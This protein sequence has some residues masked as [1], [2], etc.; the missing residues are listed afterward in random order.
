MKFKKS[1]LK[2]LSN[3]YTLANVNYF[4]KEK[5]KSLLFVTLRMKVMTLNTHLKSCLFWH[6]YVFSSIYENVATQQ[7]GH[8]LFLFHKTLLE[9]LKI[10]FFLS[11]A[12]E[13]LTGALN[14][15]PNNCQPT[16]HLLWG[17]FQKA[18]G[19][20]QIFMLVF[21]HRTALTITQ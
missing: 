3:F 21:N 12:D 20:K 18:S 11:N 10:T 15:C 6:K 7:N 1:T 4:L 13:K 5:R 9:W 19:L 8:L 16:T 2:P 14:D 17:R